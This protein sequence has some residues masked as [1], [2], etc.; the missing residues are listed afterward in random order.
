MDSTE[1]S[2]GR[3]LLISGSGE[4]LVLLH[5]WA[6]NS[7]IWQP[8]LRSLEARRRVYR[9]NLPGHGGRKFT[10]QTATFDEW[11]LDIM[12]KAPANAVWLG[13]SMGGLFALAAAARFPE[14]VKRLILVAS[15]PRFVATDNWLSAGRQAS[16]QRFS[17]Y[18]VK[19]VDAANH[20]FLK[21]QSL[22]ADK[23][24][25]VSKKLVQLQLQ[26]GRADCEALLS[27]LQVLQSVDLRPELGKISCD[28]HWILGEGDQLVP[29][30]VA[31]D[32]KLLTPSC[33]IHIIPSAGH[34]LF[35]SQ[36][37]NFLKIVN[38]L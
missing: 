7:A 20:Q 37:E 12:N 28:V 24:L 36:T 30:G 22:G 13:W 33:D 3:E 27:G 9:I 11:L 29:V 38:F 34:A 23:P 18:L 4:P 8:V 1:N 17:D 10:K 21:T 14:R 31:E 2:A 35:I 32:I 26:G 16:W 5:G 19:D 6:M 25:Q 15:T